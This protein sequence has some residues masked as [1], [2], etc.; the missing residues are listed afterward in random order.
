MNPRE[1]STF[2]NKGAYSTA[3]NN[4]KAFWYLTQSQKLILPKSVWSQG[5]RD[6]FDGLRVYNVR[7]GEINPVHEIQH[8]R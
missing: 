6:N 5:E 4:F 8:T 7:L 1:N 3:N 2:V